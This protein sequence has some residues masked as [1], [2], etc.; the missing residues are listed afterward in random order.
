M[1]NIS[2]DFN[3]LTTARHGSD[4]KIGPLL[5]LLEEK[6]DLNDRWAV[7]VK[8]SPSQRGE[9]VT[10]YLGQAWENAQTD[11][12]TIF[13]WLAKGTI[14]FATFGIIPDA[15]IHDPNGQWA[16]RPPQERKQVNRRNKKRKKVHSC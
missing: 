1:K 3:P 11:V 2:F 16:I 14:N 5:R 4:L 7:T 6:R 13:G 15:L 8:Y 12:K 9:T 10:F